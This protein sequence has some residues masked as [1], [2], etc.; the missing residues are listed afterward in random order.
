MK[1]VSVDVMQVPSGNA[2]AS[3]GDWCPV[4]V[5][6]NT[7]EGISGFGEVGLAYSYHQGPLTLCGYSCVSGVRKPWPDL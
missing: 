1:I 4:I 2:G 3:R 5:R 7:D 6:I